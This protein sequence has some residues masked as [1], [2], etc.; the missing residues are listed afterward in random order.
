MVATAAGSDKVFVIDVQSGKVI[1]QQNVGSVPRGVVLANRSDGKPTQAWTYNA[2]ENSVSVLSLNDPTQP[3]VTKTIELVDP[4]EPVYKQGRIA[5][6][7]ADASST[8]T[9]SCASCHP[10]GHTDQLLWVLKTPIVTGGNQIMPRSTMPLRG[11]RDTAPFHWDGIPGDPYGGINSQVIRGHVEPNCDESDPESTTRHLIDGALASTMSF[12]NESGEPVQ[13]ENND[14]GKPGRLSKSDR[15]AM[16]TFLLDIPFPPAQKRAY[17]NVVSER[18][19][20]GF[21]LFHVLG[22]NDP[23]KAKPNVCGDCH[24]FPHLVSTNTPGTGMDA[25]TWRGAYDRWLILPQGRLN[26]IEFDFYRRVAEQ[27]ADEQRIWQFSWANRRRFNPVWN[28]VLENSTGFSGA[29]G[30][31]VTMHSDNAS[32]ETIHD[33]LK[34]LEVT[35]KEG[36]V[37]LQVNG[38]FLNDDHQ[39]QHVHLEYQPNSANGNYVEIEDRHSISF[40]RSEVRR[41][42]SR[43]ELADL[44]RD[45]SF[46]GTFTGRHVAHTAT[47]EPQPVIWTKGP[48]QAQ[49]GRQQFPILH[50]KNKT[51]RMSS[52][53]VRDGVRAFVDGRLVPAQ[54]TRRSDSLTIELDSLPEEEGIHLLQIQNPQGMFSNDFIFHVV[55]DKK[56]AIALHQSIERNYDPFAMMAKAIREGDL[57][58]V[59]ELVKAGNN[60]NARHPDTGVTPLS[61]AA[62]FNR[63]AIGK[64]LLSKGADPKRANRDGNTPMHSAAFF[65]YPEFAKLLLE[66]D[67]DIHRKSQNGSSPLSSVSNEWTDELAG[68]YRYFNRTLDL[69]LDLKSLQRERPKMAKLLR[70]E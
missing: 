52:R 39:S 5:F 33:L 65:C 43:K 67:V 69:G 44:A 61:D 21:E 30:R 64:F 3:T 7:S 18:A 15:D 59:R 47:T 9:F 38:M 2:V 56:A 16:A 70:G 23:T 42:Y 35:T 27:G 4:T 13:T 10:D 34:A 66:H 45:G 26:I 41:S 31:Q 11:L 12:V 55:K 68:I 49:R 22:D 51:M 36:A 1:G 32:D 14:E 40:G 20:R 29:F 19:K 37:V 57:P 8:G 6:N 63:L 53:Y 24:R 48:I 46:V 54:L 60:V 17:T 25:P 28:M 62:T 58:R 50:S